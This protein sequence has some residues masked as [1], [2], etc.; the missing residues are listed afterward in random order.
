MTIEKVL[1]SIDALVPNSNTDEEKIMWLSRVDWMIKR[2]IVDAYE[3]ANKRN[4]VD[5][6]IG[7]RKKEHREAVFEYMRSNDV[8]WEEAM[9]AIPYEEIS[10]EE[11]KAHVEATRN[12]LFFC[13]YDGSTP[14][15]TV[16]LAKEPYDELYLHY[17]EAQIYKYRRE[18]D[19]YNNAI[20]DFHAVY[21]AFGNAWHRTH[22]PLGGGDFV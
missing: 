16:L 2:H 18:Y 21:E 19:A 3:G 14:R 12:D 10:Y 4:A 13:G 20:E 9:N 15:E 1:E 11:A 17:L 7:Q 8:S 22:M 6:F 5:E